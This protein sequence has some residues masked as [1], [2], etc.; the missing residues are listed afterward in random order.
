MIAYIF[1][2]S[3]ISLGVFYIYSECKYYRDNLVQHLFGF[4]MIVH[5][6]DLQSVYNLHNVPISI[7]RQ[8]RLLRSSHKL[9]K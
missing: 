7:N 6:D 4:V 1:A 9:R 2:S 8:E 3:A 5:H